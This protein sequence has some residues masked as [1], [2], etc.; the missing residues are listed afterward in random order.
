MYSYYTRVTCH[1]ACIVTI[2]VSRPLLI[3]QN[4]GGDKERDRAWL[5]LFGFHPAN[6][7]PRTV[8]ATGSVVHP[9]PPPQVEARMLG[10]TAGR[11]KRQR[12]QVIQS[13]V[14]VYYERTGRARQQRG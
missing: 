1:A 9:P 10:C 11:G 13:A 12:R 7:F 6:G 2:L 3:L 14:S 4:R 5:L 8:R